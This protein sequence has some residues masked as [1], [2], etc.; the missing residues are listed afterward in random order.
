MRR[1]GD[2]W[3]IYL[4]Q[5]EEEEEDDEGNQGLLNAE[6][7]VKSSEAGLIRRQYV[8][9]TNSQFLITNFWMRERKTIA[10]KNEKFKSALLCKE[11]IEK[12]FWL[13][14]QLFP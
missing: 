9:S 3:A 7:I 14:K 11:I 6:E 2:S 8:S 13:I 12:H 1:N 4:R 5:N 10:G